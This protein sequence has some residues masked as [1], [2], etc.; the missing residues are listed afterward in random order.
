MKKSEK[1]ALISLILPVLMLVSSMTACSDAGMGDTDIQSPVQEDSSSDAESSQTDD[2][3]ATH[4]FDGMEAVNY[5]GWILRVAG[6][7]INS[8]C[9]NVLTVEDLTGDVFNDAVYNRQIAVQDK[10]N[11]KIEETPV[12]D[13]SE[14]LTKS[15][16][17]NTADYSLG[18]MLYTDELG[19]FANGVC[20]GV[21]DMPVL[22]LSKP[23]W[24][25]GAI[26]DLSINGKMYYGLC[27]IGFGHYESSIVMFYNGVLIDNNNLES[28]YDLY[29]E[30]KWTLDAMH[31]MMQTVSNDDNGDGKMTEGDDTFGF[32]GRVAKYQPPL[33]ASGLN[34]VKWDP[35]T[36][37]CKLDLTSD[38][39]IAV[40]D[41]IYTM[42][43]DE[44]IA[45]QDGDDAM[46]MFKASKALFY[47]ALL[48]DY[49]NMR[50][51]EDDYGI[52]NWP[53]LRENMQ[54]RMYTVN[55]EALFIPADC[56]DQ[57]RLGTIMEAWSAYSYDNV[58]DD[59]VEK[60]VIGKGARDKQS[61][62]V[63]REFFYVRAYD[64][65]DAFGLSS[66]HSAWKMGITKKI[67][68]SIEE[69]SSKTVSRE[70]ADMLDGLSD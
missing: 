16:T 48:G 18:Y 60:A 55:P 32:V 49:N 43:F 67:Y 54:G 69:K 1:T 57:E 46:A 42:L 37:E 25:Q 12:D 45:I 23:Y 70:M 47:C 52:I 17:A 59:Y 31:E 66:P 61:A 19:L 21:S 8:S 62:E 63:I 14:S 30:G 26:E 15:V 41:K 28:P 35:D 24:D 6:R 11:I 10:Y 4:Y 5:D 22:D 2:A 40:G 39:I 20:I 13:V 53:T 3:S 50:D 38:D 7:P 64:L 34:I 29:T 68:A 65:A 56:R 44:S 33:S 36:Q 9:F 27:D 51:T 58:I